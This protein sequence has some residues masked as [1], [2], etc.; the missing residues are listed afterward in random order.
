MKDNH[1]SPW[2]LLGKITGWWPLD[3]YRTIHSVKTAIA[4]L[5]GLTLFKYFGWPTGQWVPITVIVVMSAQTHFGAALQ[6]AYMR[7]LGTVAGIIIATSTLFLFH[8][9]LAAMF[10]VV[11]L[12]CLCFTYIASGGGTISYAGT[13]GGVT[14]VLT[15]TGSSATIDQAIARGLDYRFRT[16][17]GQQRRY[18]Y[19]LRHS[20]TNCPT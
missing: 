10:V 12:T 11:F 18:N 1:T 13:L 5:L 16:R 3:Y 7:F 2:N 6:K 4:C 20:R 8:N 9:N 19:C 17:M 15:L 14:V